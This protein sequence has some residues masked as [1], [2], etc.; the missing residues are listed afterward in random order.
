MVSRSYITEPRLLPLSEHWG[1]RYVVDL[2]LRHLWQLSSP[3]AVIEF[4]SERG[5]GIGGERCPPSELTRRV[6]SAR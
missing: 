6:T 2:K 1:T 5:M 3:Y 4:D